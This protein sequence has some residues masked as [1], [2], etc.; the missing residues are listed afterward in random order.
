V[1]DHPHALHATD[2]DRALVVGLSKAANWQLDLAASHPDRVDGAVFVAPSL[3]LASRDAQ[4]LAHMG[5]ARSRDDI[6]PSAVPRLGRDPATHWAKYSPDYWLA[7]HEDF[8]WFF[9][10]QSFSEPYS[11]KQV[12]DAVGWG[13]E[14]RPEVLVADHAA[15]GQTRPPCAAG[16][17]RSPR[18]CWSSTATRTA[19]ARSPAPRRSR[20]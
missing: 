15:R 6:E 1:D 8:L 20:S 12:D 3:A 5:R 13:L 16:A 11:T 9:F 18:R 19:S 2:T 17:S 14:S 10:G 4:R 7:E